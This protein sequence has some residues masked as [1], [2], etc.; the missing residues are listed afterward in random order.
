MPTAT[1]AI[2]EAAAPSQVFLGLMRGAIKC[3]PI[4]FAHE[5]GEDVSRPDHQQQIQQ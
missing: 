5:V 1:L 3:R 4:D 2:T